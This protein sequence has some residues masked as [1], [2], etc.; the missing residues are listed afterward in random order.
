MPDY[1]TVRGDS[2]TGNQTFGSWLSGP[3][4]NANKFECMWHITAQ[5]SGTIINSM[6]SVPDTWNT[7][8]IFIQQDAH[9]PNLVGPPVEGALGQINFNLTVRE[10]ANPSNSVTVVGGTM[11]ISNTLA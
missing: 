7:G 8:G 2:E 4:G 10:I 5:D 1:T 11:R 9:N 6:S 3:A